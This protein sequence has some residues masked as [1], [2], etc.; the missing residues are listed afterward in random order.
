[1]ATLAV[2]SCS[3]TEKPAEQAPN[4]RIADSIL[5][6]AT[7]SMTSGGL[8][9]AVIESDTLYIFEKEDST[10]AFNIK[11]DFF[12]E[13]GIYQST[14]TARHGLVRQKQ[15]MFS[16]WGDVVAKND[17]ARLET[18]SLNWNSER[19]LITSDDFIRFERR[20]DVITGYGLEA[21]S[22]LE[23]VHILRDVKGRISDIPTSERE[24]DSL[25]SPDAKD[26]MP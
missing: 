10:S 7:I 17:S 15:K 19:N 8:K 13:Q 2:M 12:N 23:N 26:E 6:K 20:G 1:M 4:G 25:E 9:Q 18:Q 24:L 5:E 3:E 22:K 14:L 11:V 21:D 16:V